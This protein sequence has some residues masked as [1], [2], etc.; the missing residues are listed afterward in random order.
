MD[1]GDATSEDGDKGF[2]M[3]FR[4]SGS[5]W[6]KYERVW[7]APHQLETFDMKK[8][9]H[10][11]SLEVDSSLPVLSALHRR[12]PDLIV[13]ASSY[14]TPTCDRIRGLADTFVNA[15]LAG[16]ASV[17]VQWVLLGAYAGPLSLTEDDSPEP[18]MTLAPQ[19]P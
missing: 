14:W 2:R 11:T 5:D 15:S 9:R 18:S 8:M 4:F 12:R 17:A 1:T 13:F 7:R 3:S 6:S 10:K 19:E 16:A